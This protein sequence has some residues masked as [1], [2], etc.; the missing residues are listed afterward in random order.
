MGGSCVCTS[1]CTPEC[2]SGCK[3]VDGS[4]VCDICE[5]QC[6]PGCKC[7][8]GTC[9][10]DCNDECKYTE[11]VGGECEVE[12]DPLPKK[13]KKKR[14]K[15]KRKGGRFS[16]TINLRKHR[17]L[18]SNQ[19]SLFQKN[20]YTSISKAQKHGRG[21]TQEALDGNDIDEIP[22]D[23]TRGLNKQELQI[24]SGLRPSF[25][26]TSSEKILHERNENSRFQSR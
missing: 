9:D 26:E 15:R 11:W 18:S 25:M 14:R 24:Q 5:P 6:D 3:C 22:Q 1:T 7:V 2:K 10:C 4:C 20:K 12:D 23:T 8:H 17:F 13:K 16:I 19:S 21:T